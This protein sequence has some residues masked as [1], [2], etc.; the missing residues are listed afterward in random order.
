LDDNETA[1]HRDN[2]KAFSLHDIPVLKNFDGIGYIM[3]M[4]SEQFELILLTSAWHLQ[5]SKCVLWQLPYA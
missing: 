1:I 4:V 2:V 5:Q 3:E